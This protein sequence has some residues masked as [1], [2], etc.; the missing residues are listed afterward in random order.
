MEKLPNVISAEQ[1]CNECLTVKGCLG[2]DYESF[3]QICILSFCLFPKKVWRAMHVGGV[4]FQH[5]DHR[6]MQK[7]WNPT[8]DDYPYRPR[9]APM[10]AVLAQQ[11]PRE[12][13][14][15]GFKPS[16]PQRS[17]PGGNAVS[18]TVDTGPA[19]GPGQQEL[20]AML[21]PGAG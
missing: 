1:C 15:K 4:K 20:Q 10:D 3:S 14:Y 8:R 11:R 16:R 19:G 7:L 21:G 12:A 17:T 9:D 6:K 2:F 5:Y 13:V 18:Q